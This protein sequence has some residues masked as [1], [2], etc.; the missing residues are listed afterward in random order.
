MLCAVE[1]IKQVEKWVC[2]CISR[3]INLDTVSRESFTE[4]VTFGGK[5]KT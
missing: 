3:V 2:I 1:N 4:K 5:K